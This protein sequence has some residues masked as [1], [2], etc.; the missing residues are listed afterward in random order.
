MATN[1]KL[2]ARITV[3]TG[4][5]TITLT[6]A[7]GGPTSVQ[8]PAGTY[9]HSSD[10]SNANTLAEALTSAANTL[11]TETWTISV[12]TGEGAT[13]RY[14]ITC[15]GATCSV[16]FTDTELRDLLGF[17]GDKSGSTTY[18]GTNQCQGLWLASNGWQKKNGKPGGSAR[19]SDQQYS[20]NASGYVF[21]I[22][23]RDYKTAQI[24]WP[25]ET[26]SKCWT[27]DEGTPANGAFETFL[28]DGI[29]GKAAWG[30]VT[31]PIRFHPDADADTAT[32]YGTFSALEL[33]NWDP[34]ELV[35]HFAGGHWLIEL[36][37]LVEVPG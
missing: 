34:S 8:L 12:P 3:P 23:G 5:W 2:E 10:G 15:T 32:D 4:G 6:D 13:G 20:L 28:Y 18:T 30:T 14:T 7:S 19:V 11:M 26:R 1:G 9:Y 16:T 35:Q 21:A 29:W 25:M 31:G 22:Q 24:L 37:M 33:A 36:P 17:T 27:A